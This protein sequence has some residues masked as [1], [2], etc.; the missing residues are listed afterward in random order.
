MCLDGVLVKQI[1][2]NR[3]TLRKNN[4]KKDILFA[5]ILLRGMYQQ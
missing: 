4:Q 1:R 2:R 3:K 5:R